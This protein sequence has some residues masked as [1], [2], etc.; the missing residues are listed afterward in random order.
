MNKKLGRVLAAALV[1]AT[2]SLCAVPAM[3]AAP[4]TSDTDA[5]CIGR[6]KLQKSFSPNQPG[7][8]FGVLV[9]ISATRQLTSAVMSM[10]QWAWDDPVNQMRNPSVFIEP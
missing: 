9:T 7:E 3:A 6:A 8:Q 2:L 5:V 1:V 4:F 10:G